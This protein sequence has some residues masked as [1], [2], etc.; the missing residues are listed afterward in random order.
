VYVSISGFAAIKQAAITH[1]V[2]SDH[3]AEHGGRIVTATM[4][5]PMEHTW[6]TVSFASTLYLV[7][8]LEVLLKQIPDSWHAE[9]R[10]GLQE[11]LVNAVKHGNQLDSRKRIWV[12]FFIEQDAGWW[13][14]TDQ[15]R[16]FHPA[17]LRHADGPYCLRDEQECGRGLFILYQIFDHVEWNASGTELRLRKQLCVSERKPLVG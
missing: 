14:I 6:M 17:T 11:A 1:Q 4:S 8:I 10:L 15:G 12:R 7:P 16:G 3:I 13:V 9:V 2:F 5:R